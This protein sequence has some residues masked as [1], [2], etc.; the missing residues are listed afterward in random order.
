MSQWY[1]EL[2]ENRAL[3][4]EFLRGEEERFSETLERG[5]KLFEEVA[6]KG[7]ISGEDAF[8]LH[9]TYGFPWELT[10]E[11]ALERAWRSTTRRSHG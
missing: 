11:L 6:A 3:V 7:D 10:R 9:D 4:Q 5:M 2:D 8:K 1:P